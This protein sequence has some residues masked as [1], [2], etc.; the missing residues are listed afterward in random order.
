MPV[1]RRTAIAVPERTFKLCFLLALGVFDF[2]GFSSVPT[3]DWVTLD[4]LL[5]E[6]TVI[7]IL[8]ELLTFVGVDCWS[9]WF[10]CIVVI[11]KFTR[12]GYLIGYNKFVVELVFFVWL[13]ILAG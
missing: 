10:L 1:L 3:V 11:L 6:F 9:K 5:R 7:W 2:Q 12:I 13:N 4:S 8:I